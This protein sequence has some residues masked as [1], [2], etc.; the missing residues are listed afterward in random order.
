[1]NKTEPLLQ[2]AAL[3]QEAAAA[4]S[5]AARLVTEE[6]S[7]CGTCCSSCEIGKSCSDTPD[8]GLC[9]DE[10]AHDLLAIGIA[11]ELENTTS[12]S[13][14]QDLAIENLKKDKNYYSNTDK[15]KKSKT[16][17]WKV[18]KN[19]KPVR[20]INFQGLDISIEHDT[21]MV[22]HW[23]DEA[24]GEEGFR[25][26]HF[27]YGY[28]C[29][30]DGADN[31]Q[32]DCVHPSTKITMSDLSLR[33]ANEV[34]IGDSVLA[35][36]ELPHGREN[37][38]RLK[39]SKITNIKKGTANS[40][41]FTFEDDSTLITTLGHQNLVFSG[42]DATWR[43]SD[44]ITVGQEFCKLYATVEN[45]ITK[46]YAQG[47]LY[48]AYLGDGSVR[49]NHPT[50]N[51]IDISVVVS[52][53]AI[54]ER[55]S[56]FWKLLGVQTDTVSRVFTPKQS[57][58]EIEPGRIVKS[59]QDMIGLFLRKKRVISD[60]AATLQTIEVSNEQWC[61]GFLAG[62]FDTD[63]CLVRGR[64]VCFTQV[65]K[66]EETFSLISSACEKLGYKTSKRNLHLF[67]LT[68]NLNNLHALSFL[69]IINPVLLRKKDLTGKVVRFDASKV[70]KIEYLKTE[71]VAIETDAQTYIANGLATHNCFVG[72][73]DKS[74]KVYVVHQM[75]K[76]DFKQYDEDKVIVG[77]GSV[78]EAKNIY[79]MH[80]DSPKF[81][82]SMTTTTMADFKRM[83]INKSGLLK[84]YEELRRSVKDEKDARLK[85]MW[86]KI[87]DAFSEE[88]IKPTK[89]WVRNSK[90]KCKTGVCERLD[91][92]K[93]SIDD[94]FEAM[95]GMQVDGP[96]AHTGCKCGLFFEVSKSIMP[97]MGTNVPNMGMPMV[98]MIDPHD[99]ETFEGVQSLIGR[100]GSVK[101]PEL[102]EIASKIW[103]DGYNFEGKRPDQAR[104]EILG[105][106]RDQRDLL[107]VQYVETSILESHPMLNSQDTASP[108]SSDYYNESPNSEKQEA[109]GQPEG[110]SLGEESQD[111]QSTNWSDQD[112]SKKPKTDSSENTVL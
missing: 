109:L 85:G 29:R 110:N 59:T 57:T 77:A 36:D 17:N 67:V 94:T 5:K 12:Q 20:K 73:D 2:R 112:S 22:R 80:F 13:V 98:R 43:R 62:L 26:M 71:F 58:A 1:M 82:G 88:E 75:K 24:T 78:R 79:L 47:Y 63:G 4:L 14:A 66:Q 84:E 72:P 8:D 100:M 68:N 91:G 46:K 93:I 42:K 99:V 28:I 95:K 31:E 44:K 11:H 35:F 87:K 104:A 25:K 6:E 92:Q 76:P 106:L 7:E 69:S 49:L 37:P 81:L 105:F 108:G 10:F 41:K 48:G 61:R 64:E 27:P 32:L 83:F 16:F 39:H 21:G 38:R 102:M 111:T 51:Y 33:T 52:D 9:V 45:Q 74:D 54:I 96:P 34:S 89:T 90:D 3:L 65:K 103:G 18:K 15:V 107:G 56:Q 97:E 60:C 101:D 53:H 70:R 40:I 23:K 86:T 19:F 30:T 55:I 50:L